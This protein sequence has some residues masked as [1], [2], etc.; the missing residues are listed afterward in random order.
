MLEKNQLIITALFLKYNNG[1][2]FTVNID[3]VENAREDFE[4]KQCRI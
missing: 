1:Y 2:I 3:E 4:K